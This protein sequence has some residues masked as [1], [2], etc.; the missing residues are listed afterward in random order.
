MRI[1]TYLQNLNKIFSNTRTGPVLPRIVRGCP[2]N[3]EYA[4]P[5]NDAP[6]RDSI[7]LCLRENE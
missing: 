4:I 7:A 6:K 1:T 2:A 3:N 5:V